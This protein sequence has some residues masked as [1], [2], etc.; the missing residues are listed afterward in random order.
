LFFNLFLENVAQISSLKYNGVF[1]L[2]Q[3]W[4]F[5]ITTVIKQDMV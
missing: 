3:V 1:L 4:F 2:Y 5:I